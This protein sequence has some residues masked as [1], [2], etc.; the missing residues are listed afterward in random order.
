M[1]I[2]FKKEL[3]TASRGMIMIHDPKLLIKL[4]IRTIVRKFGI[5]HAAM[6]LY[7][8]DLDQFI[9]NISRGETGFKIPPNFTRFDQR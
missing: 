4:I 9:L 7:E 3:E 1:K 6:I 2:D 8:P 5:K